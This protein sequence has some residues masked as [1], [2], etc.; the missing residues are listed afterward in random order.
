M[1]GTLPLQLWAQ[2]AFTA[3]DFVIMKPDFE[4]AEIPQIHLTALHAGPSSTIYW[5]GN[6]VPT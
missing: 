3:A 4:D 6:P 5:D 1:R 2:R